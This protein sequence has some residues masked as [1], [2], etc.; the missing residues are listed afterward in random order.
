MAC[1]ATVIFI[2]TRGDT[3]IYTQS[4]LRDC[5]LFPNSHGEQK[6]DGQGQL[7]PMPCVFV[8]DCLTPDSDSN[9]ETLTDSD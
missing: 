3:G 4:F 2:E 8:T 9:S 1:L 6:E 5:C 7:Y